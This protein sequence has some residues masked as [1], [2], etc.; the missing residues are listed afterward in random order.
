MSLFE[1]MMLICFGAAWPFSILKSYRSRSNR[2]KSALFLAVVLAGYIAGTL[3]KIHF[4]P[5][6]VITHY[7]ARPGAKGINRFTIEHLQSGL[8]FYGKHHV[9][10]LLFYPRTKKI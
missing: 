7:G 4:N 8:Y 6:A 3:H 1:I 5:D 9:K 10:S 2:G